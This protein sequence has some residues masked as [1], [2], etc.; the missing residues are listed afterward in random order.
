MV[1][2]PVSIRRTTLNGASANGNLDYAMLAELDNHLPRTILRFRKV[3]GKASA[4]TG[5]AQLELIYLS[6]LW[7]VLA[8]ARHFLCGYSLKING[9]KEELAN[10]CY[11]PNPERFGVCE[12]KGKWCE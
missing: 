4:I 7:S 2:G 8:P 10:F 5:P 6:A 12:E 9:C 3:P 1:C 11:A